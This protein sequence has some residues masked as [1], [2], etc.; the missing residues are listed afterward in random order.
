[1]SK[2]SHNHPNKMGEGSKSG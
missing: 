1:M 2:C